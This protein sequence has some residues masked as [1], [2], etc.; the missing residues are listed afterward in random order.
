LK[1]YLLPK[2]VLDHVI[3][4]SPDQLKNILPRQKE[5]WVLR[6]CQL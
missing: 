4:I 2:H 1:G 5:I 6:Y 3:V